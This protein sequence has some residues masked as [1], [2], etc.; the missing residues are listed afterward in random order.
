MHVFFVPHAQV[1]L[2]MVPDNLN[3]RYNRFDDTRFDK[4][5]GTSLICHRLESFGA[6]ITKIS[7]EISEK[8]VSERDRS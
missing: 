2:V 5:R 3:L 7:F 1:D 6:E 8:V 4:I